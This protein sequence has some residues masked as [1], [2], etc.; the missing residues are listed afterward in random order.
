MIYVE[1][2]KNGL[3]K[4]LKP[5]KYVAAVIFLLVVIGISFKDSPAP[6]DT[7][8]T[9]HNSNEWF[10]VTRTI[11][12]STFTPSIDK[13]ATLY[14]TIE[15]QCSATIGSAS[16]GTVTLQYSMDNGSSWTDAASIKNSNTI[17]LAVVLNSVT[18]QRVQ[19]IFE[20]P[21]NALC[22][23]VPSTTGSTTITWINGWE[24]HTNT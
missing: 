14:Y 4:I 15:I 20:V 7:N 8:Q 19:L 13:Y 1:D 10:S 22:R 11:N 9:P 12:S 21:A 17:T 24:V 5:A 3:K 6:K 23:L 16:Q 2:I 18:I